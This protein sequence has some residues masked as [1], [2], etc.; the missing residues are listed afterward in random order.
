[1]YTKRS[2]RWPLWVLLPF[3]ACA[4]S[5]FAQ[6]SPLDFLWA[7]RAGGTVNDFSDAVAVDASGNVFVSGFFQ[8]S[9]IAF[10]GFTLTNANSLYDIFLAK[11]DNS[12]NALWA[13][14]AGGDK[15]DYSYAVAV[16]ASGNV[17]VSGFFQSST[18]A[19]DG[20]TLTNANS[21]YDIFL[22]KYDNSG[23]ALWA[24]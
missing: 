8:S 3:L 2:F 18:I 5:S 12:G 11:Y 13:R 24:R 23:N 17:F 10:D 7:K 15:L 4:C 21:L 6:T 19:F 9:T 20:F 22:A 1:M 14:R 16:D